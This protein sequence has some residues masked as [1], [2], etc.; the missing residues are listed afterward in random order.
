MDL[1]TNPTHI[2]DKLRNEKQVIED[3][4]SPLHKMFTVYS[5]RH[6]RIAGGGPPFRKISSRIFYAESDLL[7]WIE[8]HKKLTSTSDAA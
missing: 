4:D 5:L 7:A 2:P 8:S 3:P 6:W 1:T